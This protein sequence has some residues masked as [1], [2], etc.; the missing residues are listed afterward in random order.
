MNGG[1][2]ESTDPVA[3]FAETAERY[4]AWAETAPES[5]DGEVETALRLLLELTVR[6][7]DLPEPDADGPE[8]D[9]PT[10]AEWKAVLRRFT[11]IQVQLYGTCLPDDV[12]GDQHLTGDLHD[13]LADIWRDVR[14]GLDHY[15]AGERDEAS[16]QWRFSFRSHWG[17]HA[18]EALRVLVAV[19]DTS[20]RRGD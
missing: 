18:G 4:C 20:G 6:V 19:M 5:A 10:D 17:Y 3:R 1:G 8:L 7:L 15:R 11:T 2:T 9:G 14:H 12:A 16:W 13:D